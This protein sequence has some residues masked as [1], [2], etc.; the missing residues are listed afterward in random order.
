MQAGNITKVLDYY[1]A[2]ATA[3]KH[4][5]DVERAWE[6][7]F[8]HG[9]PAVQEELAEAA[10]H[11]YE[12][13]LHD[14]E[15]QNGRTPLAN[16]YAD[17]PLNLPSPELGAYK[18]MQENIYDF[19]EVLAVY[20]GKGLRLKHI[21]SGREYDIQEKAATY[22][23]HKRD[24]YLGR[25]MKVGDHC[26]IT[27]GSIFVLPPLNEDLK[28]HLRNVTNEF[29]P[30]IAY[31]VFIRGMAKN[32]NLASEM[33]GKNTTLASGNYDGSRFEE[34]DDCPVCQVMKK[35]K[36]EGREPTQEELERAMKKDM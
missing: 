27:G 28:W 31:Q 13:F 33:V 15:L 23:L 6:E 11:F 14:F 12:W 29:N 34:Y 20:R 18:D 16:F 22:E 3:S 26:E 4:R 19:F 10:G 5:D 30:K 32:P 35:A 25:V 1:F 2:S 17:N 24:T 21:R 9:I 36:M 7:F 8:V